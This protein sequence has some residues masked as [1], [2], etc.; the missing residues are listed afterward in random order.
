MHLTLWDGS[1]ISRWARVGALVVMSPFGTHANSPASH[2]MSASGSG[3]DFAFT[4]DFFRDGSGKRSCEQAQS[5]FLGACPL[6]TLM[7]KRS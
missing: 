4:A 1:N 5:L 2:A 7:A 3:A 6:S